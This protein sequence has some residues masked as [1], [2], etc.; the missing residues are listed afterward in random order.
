MRRRVAFLAPASALLLALVVAGVAVA[1]YHPSN[2]G[3]RSQ[4]S[5][6]VPVYKGCGTTTLPSP[7]G[8]GTANKQHGGPISFPSCSPP[9]VIGPLITSGTS[10]VSKGV[11]SLAL[12][13]VCQPPAPSTE[14]PPCSTTAGD[15]EDVSIVTNNSDIRCKTATSVTGHCSSTNSNGT[16]DYDGQVVGTATIRITDKFNGTLGTTTGGTASAT[17]QDVPFSVGIQC[18]ATGPSGTSTIGG[19]CNA[20]TSADAIFS[21][22]P[23]TNLTVRENKGAVVEIGQ[24]ETYDTGTDGNAVANPLLGHG[25]CPPSCIVNPSSDTLSFAEGIYLP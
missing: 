6:L 7:G 17:T 4:T 18:A 24:I 10:T 2:L 13:V 9:T 19:T 16:P 23:Y 21:A 11:G 15:N 25:P 1:Y 22:S 5:A 12:K 20:T 3:A 14:N 8:S